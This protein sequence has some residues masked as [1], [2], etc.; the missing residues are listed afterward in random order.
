MSEWAVMGGERIGRENWRWGWM[1]LFL[2]GWG[3][4]EE[5]ASKW[6]PGSH[7]LSACSSCLFQKAT[8]LDQN[9]QNFFY[10][11]CQKDTHNQLSIN[12][13]FSMIFCCNCAFGHRRGKRCI[14][15]TLY[16]K[17]WLQTT[18]GCLTKTV[19]SHP[20]RKNNFRPTASFKFYFNMPLK[21]V[22]TNPMKS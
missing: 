14:A 22:V 3:I 9:I 8:H 15:C 11:C 4:Q 16:G 10:R 12:W 7:L 20:E 1:V 13:S 17:I 2:I 21:C 18:R 6:H 5:G 19:M